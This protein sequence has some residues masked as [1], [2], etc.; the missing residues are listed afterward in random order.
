MK[1]LL[2]ALFLGLFVVS[3]G[4][5]GSGV[6]R[7]SLNGFQNGGGSKRKMPEGNRDKKPG[8]PERPRHTPRKR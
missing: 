3:C 5:V 1:S 8:Q 7:S 4:K 6:E 2:C